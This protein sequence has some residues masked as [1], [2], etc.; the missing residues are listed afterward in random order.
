MFS[1]NQKI[2]IG[3]IVIVIILAFTAPQ[4]YYDHKIEKCVN[5]IKRQSKEDKSTMDPIYESMC[6]R[7]VN[8]GT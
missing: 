6:H 8:G 5:S 4:E 2:S 1:L 3:A 7:F